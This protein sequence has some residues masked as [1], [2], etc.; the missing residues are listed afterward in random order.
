MSS[1]RG[2]EREQMKQRSRYR[3]QFAFGAGCVSLLAAVAWVSEPATIAGADPACS[4]EATRIQQH[5]TYLPNCR[6]FEMT[7]PEDKNG[8]EVMPDSTRTQ[9]AS[10]GNAIALASTVGFGDV[11]GMGIA[12]QYLAER[13]TAAEPGNNGWI[14]HAI[15]PRQDPVSMKYPGAGYE[16]QYAVLSP[17]LSS[18]VF[19]S[20]SPL[21][22]D[23]YVQEVAD[24]YTRDDLA[25]AGEGTYALASGCAVC[26]E[27]TVP[28][29]PYPEGLYYAAVPGVAGVS[30]DN[31]V[32]LFDSMLRLASG[33]NGDSGIN[34][35]TSDVFVSEHGHTRLVGVVPASGS[36]CADP[37]CVVP[38]GSSGA[39]QGVDLQ[40]M[41]SHL[42]H[43]LSADGSRAIFTSHGIPYLRN[44][45]AEPET[46]VQLNASERSTPDPGA[47]GTATYWD[48]SADASRIFFTSPDKLTDD[49]ESSSSDLYMWEAAPDA[50]GHHLTRISVQ[51]PSQGNSASA[52]QVIGVSEDGHYV[53]FIDD[54]QLV[55]GEPSPGGY[56]IYLWHD[57]PGTQQGGELRYIGPIP[58]PNAI[59][60]DNA[61][62]GSTHQ[63][64]DARVSADGRHLLFSAIN[65]AGLLSRYGGTDYDHGHC[66]FG[67]LGG[68][69]CRELYLYDAEANQ[70]QCAT[71]RPDGMA[72]TASPEVNASYGYGY[73]KVTVH[74]NDPLSANGRYVFFST[75]EPLVEADSNGISDA[76]E[77]DS[78]TGQVHL[79]STGQGADPSYFMD[80][81][82]SGHD[83]FF[84]TRE[85]LVGWDT[86]KGYDVYDVRIEGGFPEPPLL[87][88]SCQGDACQPPAT[89]LNDPTPGSATLAGPGNQRAKKQAS[90]RRKHKHRRHKRAQHK[91][92]TTN[93]RGGSK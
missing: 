16:P 6:A 89:A 55:A 93:G 38:P 12:S 59:L 43:A 20:V 73:S 15:T 49:D 17:S 62:G 13:S 65:G 61:P 86:D 74:R 35:P 51:D 23:P 3:R 11:R 37:A 71:C 67:G 5:S 27:T 8:G 87:P 25:A 33:S 36:E 1:M 83:A 47:S 70:L 92:T 10:D 30:A 4:N 45:A 31:S 75:V 44:L 53:Y 7:S 77:Y 32:V 90:K 50:E 34:N 26:E 2:R 82:S 41:G 64:I 46:T 29:P 84:A 68:A 19:Q 22:E 72:A 80:A 88:P 79:L 14:V 63:E 85:R 28:V 9:A 60:S 66:N 40:G 48:A 56:G 18:G 57:G 39:G 76:Y 78:S 54:A 81:S 69:G 21:T 42:P 91:R 58:G 52:M 24:L